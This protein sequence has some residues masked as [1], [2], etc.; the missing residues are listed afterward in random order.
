MVKKTRETKTWY[1]HIVFFHP[2]KERATED[3]MIRIHDQTGAIERT[4][5]GEKKEGTIG[6]SNTPFRF[7]ARSKPTEY[8]IYEREFHVSSS[9]GEDRLE[10]VIKEGSR[11]LMI[12]HL[13]S[14]VIH[15][16]VMLVGDPTWEDA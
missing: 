16:I 5:N 10:V 12:H 8:W 2:Q 1:V 11:F 7:F 6:I 14:R 15:A 9:R 13:D 4:M 3:A